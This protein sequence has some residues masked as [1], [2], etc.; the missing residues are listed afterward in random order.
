MTTIRHHV[1]LN[2]WQKA[3]LK[4]SEQN[5]K[6]QE[7]QN[8]PQWNVNTEVNLPLVSADL[9]TTYYG[10]NIA[11]TDEP[12]A[13]PMAAPVVGGNL[14]TEGERVYRKLGTFW[15]DPEDGTVYWV[16]FKKGTDVIKTVMTL[17]K[18]DMR[19]P[20][21]LRSDTNNE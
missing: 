11:K 1:S 5:E 14:P 10:L 21:E 2:A 12:Q 16:T 8:Q 20:K 19:I 13:K 6:E 4:P 15:K 18:N 7:Q 17:N 9:L 3:P